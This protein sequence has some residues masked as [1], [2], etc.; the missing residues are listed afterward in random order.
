MRLSNRHPRILS[1]RSRLCHAKHPRLTQ[2]PVGPRRHYG[3][4]NRHHR[5]EL[6]A[7]VLTCKLV[8]FKH[9]PGLRVEN[10][11]D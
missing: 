6:N 10:W 4:S 1:A 9:V 5:T 2:S 8:D 3:S 11:L 7:L